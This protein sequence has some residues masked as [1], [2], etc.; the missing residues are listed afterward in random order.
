MY[1]PVGFGGGLKQ[2]SNDAQ[3]WYSAAAQKIEQK[4]SNHNA[5][6]KGKARNIILFVGDG[7]GV[8]TIT[9]ARIFAG[10]QKGLSGEEYELSFD[11]FAYS[12]LARTYT[13]NAQTPDSAGTMTALVTGVKT[14]SGLLSVSDAALRQNCQSQTGNTLLSAVAL[15]ELAG[16]ATGIISTARLTHATPAATYA[17]S[18]ERDWE[19]DSDMPAAAIRAGCED[20]ASQMMNFAPRLREHVAKQFPSRSFSAAQLAHVNGIDIILGGG[21]RSFLPKNNQSLIHNIK[22]KGKRS[23]GRN[24][25]AEWQRSHPD[26]ILLHDRSALA[27]IGNQN[28][29][30]ILGLFSPSHMAY[31]AQRREGVTQKTVVGTQPSLAEM[32]R[33]AIEFLDHQEEGFFLMVEAGRIDHAHH[34]GNAFNALSDTVALS[35][36]VA[37]AVAHTN[38]QETLIIVTADHSHVFTMAGYPQRGNPILGKVKGLDNAGKPS[39][40]YSLDELGM[41]YTTL[42]YMNGRGLSLQLGDTNAD[43]GYQQAISPG[44]RDLREID[45]ENVGFHQEALIGMEAETHGGE[46]V[47]IYAQ[48]PGAYLLSGSH[49]Q[50]VVF[51]AMNYAGSLTEL[52]EKALSKK[53]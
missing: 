5:L 43:S 38:A 14:K 1:T 15:A 29:T 7:M 42:G 21:F 51:H 28:A 17:H 33:T 40:E 37:A 50:N 3:Q 32:T 4:A 30:A 16:K 25:M 12:G 52:A 26:G 24:L 39:D 2:Y 47:A 9:A 44:R 41:P 6:G 10:Q 48:G 36:A 27:T 49:E 23:D 18:V 19:N 31:E 13:T 34:A 11:R 45:T 20:I 22:A 8:S 35:E 46:D 53:P